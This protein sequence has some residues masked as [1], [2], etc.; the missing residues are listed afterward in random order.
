MF[1]RIFRPFTRNARE[2]ALELVILSCLAL[3]CAT[4]ASADDYPNRPITLI[5]PFPPGGSTTVMARN[6]AD[7][8]SAALGQQIVVENRGG[9]GGTIGARFFRP[10]S[11]HCIPNSVQLHHYTATR[12]RYEC[13]RG[14]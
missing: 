7:K 12:A 14:L 2:R 13:E 3:V 9:G 1:R 11:P 4:I 6:V 5:V 8:M 10:A